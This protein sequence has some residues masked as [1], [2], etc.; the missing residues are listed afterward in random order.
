VNPGDEVIVKFSGKD[1][2]GEVISHNRGWVMCRILLDPLWDYG[3]ITARLDP[4]PV[5]CVKDVFVRHA[6]ESH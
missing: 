3:S 4:E 5:V 2:P 6:D 1:H